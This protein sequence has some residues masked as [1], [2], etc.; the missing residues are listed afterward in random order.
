MVFQ[1]RLLSTLRNIQCQIWHPH[2]AKVF[3]PIFPHTHKPGN[4]AQTKVKTKI[5]T[6]F[7]TQIQGTQIRPH[8]IRNFTPNSNKF[9]QIQTEFRSNSDYRAPQGFGQDADQ[10]QTNIQTKTSNQ[11]SDLR[12]LQA[13]LDQSP[14]HQNQHCMPN[15]DQNSDQ[16]SDQQEQNKTHTQIRIGT[17]LR[18]ICQTSCYHPKSRSH[19]SD[20]KV[21]QPP[22]DRHKTQI[23]WTRQKGAMGN[24]PTP[25]KPQLSHSDKNQA[26]TDNK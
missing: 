11:N 18:H 5:K 3:L 8:S 25:E 23:L 15:S 9:F 17:I 22:E 19:I 16:D 7:Q 20:N 4:Q 14:H 26:L 6:C 21:R 2:A 1:C 12:P 13:N 10:F 24:W